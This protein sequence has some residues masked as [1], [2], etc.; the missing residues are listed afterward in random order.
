MQFTDIYFP[1]FLSVVFA[2]YWFALRRTLAGQNALLLTASYIFY[3]WWDWRFLILI[4]ITTLSTFGSAFALHGSYR[5]MALTGNIVLNIGILVVF[6]Y[7]NFFGENLARLFRITGIELD[8]FT[9]DVLLP[10]GISFYTFQ[11]ISYSVDVYRRQI[12]P[13][14]NL[15][16][17]ATYVAYFPQLVAGPIEKASH[18]LPQ[19]ESPRRWNTARATEGMRMILIGLVKKLCIADMLAIYADRLYA[20]DLASPLSNL[21]AGTIFTFQIYFDFSA[22]SEIARG[23]SRLLGIELIANFRF[24]CLARNVVDFWQRWHISLMQ[25]FRDYLYIPLGGSRHGRA[26]T[27]RNTAIIFLLSGLWHGAGWNFVIWGAYWAT[28]YIVAKQVLRQHRTDSSIRLSDMP[29]IIATFGVVALGFYLFRCSDTVQIANGFINVWA[30]ILAFGAAAAMSAL[31]LRYKALRIA[32]A[33]LLII[34]AAAALWMIGE[35]WYLVLKAW[36]LVPLLMVGA[37]EWR[38][39]NAGY[40]LALAPRQRWARMVLYQI[41]L[42]MI[43]LSEP[44]EM[45]FIYF[46]F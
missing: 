16:S 43:L 42:A 20:D 27:V 8:W 21:A 22:Y 39:R 37:I 12:E 41:C 31:I 10:V 30:Y 28:V 1:L 18:L 4:I 23:V 19:I 7:L 9:I 26:I 46:Q 24:P 11:A 38:C 14:R 13:T 34:G 40:P 44:T 36:W 33:I 45:S 29:R 32:L 35:R 5:R 2:L 3:G 6:K 17:F 15:L 25:W